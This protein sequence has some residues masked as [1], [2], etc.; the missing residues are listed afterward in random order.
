[1]KYFLPLIIAFSIFLNPINTFAEELILAGGCFWCLEHDLESFKGI[2]FVQ[3]GYSGGDSQNPTY[4]NHDGHQEV[5]LVNYDSQLVSLA[6]ILRLYM[7]NI[8]PLDGNGQFC[9][10]GDSYRPVIFFKDKIEET[11]AKNAIVSASNEL[12]LPLE[13]IYVE[14]KPRGQFW[15]AEEYHQDFAERNELK[16]KFYRYSCGRDQ[17]L[18]KLW[19]NNAR[20]NN[21][22]SE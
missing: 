14:L 22:W 5:V 17:K 15:L 7:R 6:E 16:Y 20:S 9:D 2:N 4:E 19:G 8:D 1:M 10:R 18:D 3:S 21:P 11:Y 12:R 13:K